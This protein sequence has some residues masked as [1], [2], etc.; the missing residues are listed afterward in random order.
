MNK[1]HKVIVIFC[2]IAAIILVGLWY[3]AE[4]AAAKDDTVYFYFGNTCPHC[5]NVEV[6]MLQNNVSEKLNVVQKEVYENQAN[7]LELQKRARTCRI[8]ADEIGVPLVYYKGQ[9]YVGE[10]QGIQLF[11]QLLGAK[12]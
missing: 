8:N 12:P 7:A 9:C 6:W 4:R 3:L 5:K 11:E 1:A 10:D 2:I